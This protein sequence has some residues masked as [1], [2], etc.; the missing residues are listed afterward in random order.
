MTTAELGKIVADCKNELGS[1]PR[2]QRTLAGPSLTSSLR[3][4]GDPIA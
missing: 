3:D 2:T 4:T 1:N